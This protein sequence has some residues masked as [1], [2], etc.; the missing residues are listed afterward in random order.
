[1][2]T[3]LEKDRIFWGDGAKYDATWKPGDLIRQGTIL[4]REV[5]VEQVP[6]TEVDQRL[7]V[8]DTIE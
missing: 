2:E 1:M 8:A 3:R 6:Q 4:Y 7:E 5:M